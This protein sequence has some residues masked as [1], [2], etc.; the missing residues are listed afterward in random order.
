MCE[1]EQ[2]TVAVI[3]RLEITLRLIHTSFSQNLNNS[4]PFLRYDL[5]IGFNRVITI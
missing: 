5:T 2:G 3:I 4:M 1:N